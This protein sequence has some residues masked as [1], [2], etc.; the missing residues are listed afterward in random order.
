MR[1][2]RRQQS[3]PISLRETFPR[4][5]GIY[6]QFLRCM[7]QRFTDQSW[8]TWG[9]C[10]LTTRSRMSLE[11]SRLRRSW[12]V[13]GHNGISIREKK[14]SLI[15]LW[16]QTREKMENFV[17]HRLVRFGKQITMGIYF[18]SVPRRDILREILLRNTSTTGE[19]NI[20]LLFYACDVSY[21]PPVQTIQT[22]PSAE[23]WKFE[24][25][26]T[27]MNSFDQPH[28]Q[29]ISCISQYGRTSGRFD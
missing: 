28:R 3:D 29:I 16:E 6:A 15:S 8:A 27:Q 21:Q 12:G 23:Q 1:K 7:K 19:F 11:T 13:C 4:L 14:S 10:F 22:Y 26:N 17:S 25:C 9:I 20:H 18:Q 2:A 5:Q 24:S